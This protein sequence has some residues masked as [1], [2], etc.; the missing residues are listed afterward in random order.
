MDRLSSQE[1][2]RS[3]EHDQDLELA[4]KHLPGDG[5]HVC[6]REDALGVSLGGRRF[7][8]EWHAI[9]AARS[10]YPGV[11]AQPHAQV[12]WRQQLSAVRYVQCGCA[13]GE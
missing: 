13:R 8:V 1:T 2:L 7:E 6:E 9:N 3:H 5:H 11:H 12:R 4:R 10:S